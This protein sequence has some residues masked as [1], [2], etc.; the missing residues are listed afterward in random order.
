MSHVAV[1]EHL[2]RE[3]SPS[4][5][6]SAPKDECLAAFLKTSRRIRVSDSMA[7]GDGASALPFVMRLK[8]VFGPHISGPRVT[9]CK[10]TKSGIV[11]KSDVDI[12]KERE[13]NIKGKKIQ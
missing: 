13:R 3:I 2:N 11:A 12:G 4:C 8:L 1:R 6:S 7:S 9:S 10:I 5:F